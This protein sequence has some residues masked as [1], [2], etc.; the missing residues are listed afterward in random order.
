MLDIAQ[1]LSRGYRKC[2]DLPLRLAWGF[3]L[4]HQVTRSL[5]RRLSTDTENTSYRQAVYYQVLFIH[6][7]LPPRII[8]MSCYPL[9]A[10]PPV[11]ISTLIV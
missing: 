4:I 11:P 2:L 7:S 3:A 10:L 6:A 5:S 9:F 8:A 1:C